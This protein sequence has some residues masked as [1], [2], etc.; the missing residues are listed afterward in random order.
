MTSRQRRS[1]RRRLRFTISGKMLCRTLALAGILT[2]AG[3]LLS[4]QV[5]RRG[6]SV[7]IGVGFTVE[8]SGLR[9]TTLPYDSPAEKAGLLVNDL[10]VGADGDADGLDFTV[11]SAILD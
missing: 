2:A 4:A 6:P 5:A 1:S 10:I 9:V 3:L 7:W 8:K 11:E